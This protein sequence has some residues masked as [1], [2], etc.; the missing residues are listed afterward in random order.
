LNNNFK[1]NPA[2][3]NSCTP[4]FHLHAFMP[5]L[6]VPK[7]HNTKISLN[8]IFVNIPFKQ[9]QGFSTYNV[10]WDKNKNESQNY[11]HQ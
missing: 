10:S 1:N 4:M 5:D 6:D 9:I 2:E 11:F 3:R 8:S 7:F